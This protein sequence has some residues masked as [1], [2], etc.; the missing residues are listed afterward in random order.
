MHSRACASAPEREMIER[1]RALLCTAQRSR[2]PTH[3]LQCDHK[4]ALDP[5]MHVFKSASHLL[6]RRPKK[7][8]TLRADS[9]RSRAQQRARAR[10]NASTQTLPRRL[11]FQPRCSRR[12]AATTTPWRVAP[13]THAA[14]AARAAPALPRW[15]SR[16]RAVEPVHGA[17]DQCALRVG[18]RRGAGGGVVCC[19]VWRS[20]SLFL[21][22]LCTTPRQI[23]LVSPVRID[24][25]DNKPLLVYLPGARVLAARVAGGG[26]G[27]GACRPAPPP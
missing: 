8:N 21:P 22:P 14:A 19:P 10:A 25:A 26:G 6:C 20:P 9:S 18:W 5:R 24:D 23:K 16:R 12:D 17:C 27:G 4:R 3:A 7:K 13:S 1:L 15:R 11:V 2:S